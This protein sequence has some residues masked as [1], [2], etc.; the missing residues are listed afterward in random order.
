MKNKKMGW[1]LVAILLV[2]ANLVFGQPA[3]STISANATTGVT[4]SWPTVQTWGGYIV[5]FIGLF[6]LSRIAYFA[7]SKQR[8]MSEQL[9]GFVVYL[10]LM[11]IGVSAQLF[12]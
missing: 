4:S 5:G 3:P 12:T 9:G 1:L 10:V 7:I 8:E 6:G 11:I 2:G